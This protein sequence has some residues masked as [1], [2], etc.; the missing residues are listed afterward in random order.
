M[1]NSAG[2]PQWPMDDEGTDEVGD[3][4]MLLGK[5]L[6]EPPVLLRLQCHAVQSLQMDINTEMNLRAEM[7]LRDWTAGGCVGC[8]F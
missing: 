4:F 7:N 6:E 5:F 2:Q 1:S 8:M 3:L